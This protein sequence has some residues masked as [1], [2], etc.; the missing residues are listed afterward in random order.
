MASAYALLTRLA[1]ISRGPPLPSVSTVNLISSPDTLPLYLVTILLPLNSRTTVNDMLSPSTLP[2]EIS[3]SPP[4]PETVP[5]SLAPS[6]FRFIFAVCGPFLPCISSY[7]LP[8]TSAAH[9]TAATIHESNAKR[10][11]ILFSLLGIQESRCKDGKLRDLVTH[12][13]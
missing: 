7:H 1:V 8:V 9:A 2:S 10:S 3:V 4:R 13:M 5:V 12:P 6:A 11:F